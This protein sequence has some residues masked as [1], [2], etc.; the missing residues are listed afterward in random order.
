MEMNSE[1]HSNTKIWE[2]AP[3]DKVD[4]SE[5]EDESYPG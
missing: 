5:E 3:L 1:Q 4:G 2:E